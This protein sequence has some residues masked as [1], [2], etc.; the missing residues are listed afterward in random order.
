LGCVMGEM[1]LQRGLFMGNDEIDQWHKITQRLGMPPPAMLQRCD[2]KVREYIE[3]ASNRADDAIDLFEEISQ[4]VGQG[5]ELESDPGQC[6]VEQ[7]VDCLKKMLVLDPD[8][9]VPITDLIEHPFL[10]KYRWPPMETL[11]D[12][13]LLA[14][15]IDFQR[16][17]NNKEWS[18]TK[19]K[20]I[21][22]NFIVETWHSTEQHSQTK[23]ATPPARTIDLPGRPGWYPMNLSSNLTALSPLAGIM[24]YKAM[25]G[26]YLDRTKPAL[27]GVIVFAVTLAIG[28][29]VKHG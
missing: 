3:S 17:F 6:T 15:V 23:V 4:G 10:A 5:S 18:I 9:R 28:R 21:I 22:Y 7:A 14:K 1:I 27:C 26:R 29:M 8:M 11:P 2:D 16:H 19:W 12:P 20:E 13:Q 25:E 24:V